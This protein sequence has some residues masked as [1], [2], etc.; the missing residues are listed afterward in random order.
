MQLSITRNSKWV[1]VYLLI[2][3]FA[4]VLLSGL[5]GEV[6]A[7]R[8]E[9]VLATTTSTYDSG[10]LSE[11]NPVFEERFNVKI[12]T[13][14]VGTGAAIRHAE[15]GDADVIMVHARPAE[16]EFMKEGWGVNRRDLMYNDFIIVGPGDDPAGLSEM[17]K[18]AAAFQKIANSGDKFVSR[19][20]DSGT[21]KKELSI[22]DAAGVEPSGKWYL[23]IG[24]G[25]GDAL[26]QAD[27]M[28]AYT[29][30]DRGTYLSM[31]DNLDL[32][33]LI[34]GPVKGGDQVLMNPYG[35][36]AVN[37]A[38]YPSVNYSMA[39]AYIGFVTSPRGQEIVG[40]HRV[41]GEQLFFP[42]ALSEK[43]NFAQ[44]VPEDFIK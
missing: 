3:V 14:A 43:P 10:L 20:D 18:A 2:F 5:S 30:S 16:D 37:P 33:I 36:I 35:V 25:M 28:G 32:E 24:K 7:A 1:L 11:L 26:V 12:K 31:K 4:L 22:W 39:M 41:K 40:N 27:K 19:G 21:N 15:N 44:Y 8:E 23:E 42:N 9:L 13:I 29:M 38:K 34:Q 6:L 17:S